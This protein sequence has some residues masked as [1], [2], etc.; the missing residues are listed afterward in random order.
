M[1]E[2]WMEE[3]LEITLKVMREGEF[4][5]DDYTKVEKIANVYG[6]TIGEEMFLEDE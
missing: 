2:T 3:L 6:F 4:S 1:S 5:E